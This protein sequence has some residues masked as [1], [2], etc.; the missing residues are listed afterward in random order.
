MSL[1]LDD[2]WHVTVQHPSGAAAVTVALR[3]L[4]PGGWPA[5]WAALLAQQAAVTP[6]AVW[7]AT[8]E[9]GTTTVPGLGLVAGIGDAR[10]WPGLLRDLAAALGAGEAAPVQG[11]LDGRGVYVQR[12]SVMGV[13]GEA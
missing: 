9:G 13:G 3:H 4:P 2:P 10:L 12:P 1:D 5:Q 7:D 8:D 11:P 6:T